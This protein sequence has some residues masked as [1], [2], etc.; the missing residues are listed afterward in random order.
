MRITDIGVGLP[1]VFVDHGGLEVAAL[2]QRVH[3]REVLNL[4]VFAEN[5]SLQHYSA[6]GHESE[7]GTPF[8]R[9]CMEREEREAEARAEAQ[10]VERARQQQKDDDLADAR[11]MASAGG[12]LIDPSKPGQD[13]AGYDPE[14][15]M[16]D[17][18][19]LAQPKGDADLPIG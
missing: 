13:L 9:Y 6:V 7:G 12:P 10:H 16:V 14:R 2:V 18:P 11:T 4:V 5:G 19:A 1:V 17:E 8:W 15:T 3:S